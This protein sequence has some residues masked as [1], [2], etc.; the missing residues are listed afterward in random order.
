[1]DTYG[2][3]PASD[4]VGRDREVPDVDRGQWHCQQ[5]CARRCARGHVQ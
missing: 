5:V 4:G 1:M 3:V 2:T